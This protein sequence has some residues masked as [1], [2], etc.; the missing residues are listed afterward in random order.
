MT[1]I[2]DQQEKPHTAPSTSPHPAPVEAVHPLLTTDPDQGPW[3]IMVVDDDEDVHRLTQLVLRD[4]RFEQRA[5]TFL[6]AYSG[7]EAYALL[8][9][10]PK[11]AVLLL[12]VVMETD[13]AGLELVRDIREKL[14]NHL[15]RIILRTGQ[16]GLA[17]EFRVVAEY[18]INDYREKT[19]LTSQKLI[20][21][22]TIA[23]RGFRDLLAIQRLS[24]QKREAE[25]RL[26]MATRI[27]EGALTAAEEQLNITKMVLEHAVE[28]VMITDAQGTILSVNPAFCAITGFA[29]AEAIGQTPR[30]LRS[31]RQDVPFYRD[32]W[33]K[34]AEQGY[35][36][37]D[38]WN[39]RKNGEA[40]PQLT[41]I[42]AIRDQAGKAHRYISVF[43]DL[44]PLQARD[45]ALHY[46][47]QHDTLTGLPNRELFMDRLSQAIGHASRSGT[48]LL[49]LFFDI[50]RFQNVNNQWDYIC[51]DQLLQEIAGR[52]REFIREGDTLARMEGDAFAFILR[53]VRQPEDALV[54][55]NKLVKSF[56]RPFII[57]QTELLITI[58]IGITLYP[59]DGEPPLSL[60]KNAEIALT[61]AKNSGRNTYQ[62]YKPTMGDQVDRRLLL[63]KNLRS[64]LENQEFIL[65]YQPKVQVRSKRIVGMEALVR[66]NSPHSGMISPG[67]FI[68]VA[69]ESGLIIP[70]G[71]WILATACRQ[72]Q[73]WLAAGHGPLKV[74]VNLSPRQFRQPGIYAM[75]AR[76]LQETGLPP[77]SLELEITESMLVD[78]VEEAIQLLDRLRSL[79]LSI[80]MDDF[81]TGY[82]S[83]SY[84]KRFPIQSIKIDQSFVRDL[85]QQT[86]DRAIVQAIV[87]MGKSLRLLVVAE[88]VETQEQWN[89]IEEN[90]IDEIQGYFYSRPLSADAF[91]HFL[92]EKKSL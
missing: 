70:L 87:A 66:W 90:N 72:T 8:T 7:A 81:G 57:E 49:V 31:N 34:I 3:L 37:G 51:G 55:V 77:D 22:V 76:T 78:N 61:R 29:T 16:A 23:L 89:F 92:Q 69:E 65:H 84:L 59:D 82:S 67:E 56:A 83:L 36:K 73:A 35:W 43:H 9:Q 86:D 10:H 62:F 1:P 88:G 80:A 2:M 15:T 60:I 32:M 20:G 44:T 26:E 42:T 64:A 24:S 12:D 74:A 91:V 39:R 52:L 18:D 19:E 21:V 30:I 63:E 79:G 4:L 50:D 25:E 40:Y 27:F 54:L 33:Q 85:P 48:R 28:G 38:I 58:S 11:T 46:A 6:H 17:P 45:Q 53:E 75:I 68:P 5:V 47:G 41:T 14:Q 13:H 71:E